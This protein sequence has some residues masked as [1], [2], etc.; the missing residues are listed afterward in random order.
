MTSEDNHDLLIREFKP[1]DRA[2]CL[3]IFES[4]QP[5]YFTEH[6]YTEF[7][8][9]LDNPDC[10]TYSVVELNGK[11]VACGGL[12]VADDGQHVG[13]AWGM[14]HRDSQRNGIG[15]QLTE[16]R[17]EQMHELYPNLEQRLATSQ[18]TFGFY[19]KLGFKT[20]KV[21]E[22]GF[23]PGLDRYDMLRNQTC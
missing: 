19:E 12:Y 7:A 21:T 10:P 13:M 2:K 4:N 22:N 23:G 15:R 6:E 8:D 5:E 14:V 16:F 3:E 11:I 9:W 1:T 17:L 20:L 18:L